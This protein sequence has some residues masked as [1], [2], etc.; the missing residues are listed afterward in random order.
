MVQLD[1]EKAFG[2]VRH[3]F[4]FAVFSHVALGKMIFQGFKICYTKPTTQLV[5]NKELSKHI[6]MFFRLRVRVTPV[7]PFACALF[8]VVA[9][10]RCTK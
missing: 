5:I 7:A 8:R 9:L 1:L 6:F 4:I 10:E 2:G 3:H